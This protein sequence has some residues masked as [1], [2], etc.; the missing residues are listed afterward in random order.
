MFRFL[1]VVFVI[2]AF[3][4]TLYFSG[5]ALEAWESP[6]PETVAMPKLPKPKKQ[7]KPKRRVHPASRTAPHAQPVTQAAPARATW[8]VDLNALCRHG[9]RQIASIPPPSGLHD[10][11]RYLRQTVRLNG[12]LNRQGLVLARRS[13]NAKVS[14][15]L[16]ELFYRDE[17]AMQKML[18]LA[19]NGQHEQL[20]RYAK[21][22]IP[23]A[24]AENQVLSKLGATDCMLDPDNS[25][26]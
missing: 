2:G 20:G 16:A 18:R 23:L 26:V 14:S 24:R 22:L 11:V 25:P 8:L 9:K 10:T 12:S 1:A 17:E 6:K 13:G 7:A 4:A 15:Q 21:S 3:G 5:D 19:Q